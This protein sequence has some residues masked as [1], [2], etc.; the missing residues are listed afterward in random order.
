MSRPQRAVSTAFCLLFLLSAAL[1]ASETEAHLV[2]V[3]PGDPIY[4]YW[5]HIG[6]AISDRDSGESMFYDFGNFSFH[7]EHFYR[8][9]VM[10]RML[11]LG[12]KT[13]TEYFLAYSMQEDRDLRLYPLNLGEQELEILDR[14][15]RWWALPENREYLY[16]YFYANCSTIIRDVL[17]EAVNGALFEATAQEKRQ[18]FRHYSRTG[19]APSASAELLVH[20]L[21]GPRQDSPIS[22]WEHMFLPEAV[23]DA[24]M[25]LEYTAADG[26]TRT[27][28]GE[29]LVLKESDRPKVP[30]EP[31]L[32]W[33]AMLLTGLLLS[34]VWVIL[35]RLRAGKGWK[36]TGA[37]LRSLLILSIGLP[38]L[39]L[40]FMMVFTDH[41]STY[42]NINVAPTLPT[43]LFA[44][45]PVIQSI[46][47]PEDRRRKLEI[48]QSWIWT[49]NLG[50]LVLV[51]LFR[52]VGLTIQDAF[53]FWAL[54]LPLLLT[55]SRPG[56]K[57][58]ELLRKA[59]RSGD[60]PVQ[61]P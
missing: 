13:P 58:E 17:D 49:V 19:A 18:S 38:G 25:G 1:Q 33:P 57:V 12:L 21:L 23:A 9:F 53:A 5:G 54:F 46:K 2:I 37:V 50:A 59:E 51:M 28:A 55:A 45:I 32:L 56:L 24:A 44:L 60:R 6:I 8:D 16:D 26:T 15:L 29:P 22:G 42:G 41:A 52:A 14:R 20:F 31:R 4:T 61:E 48:I 39:I 30:E 43:L 35:R 3:G 34:A 40:T 10:G 27:L 36:I 11:Y 7:S 47:A